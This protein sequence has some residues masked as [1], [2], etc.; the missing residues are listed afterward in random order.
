MKMNKK[1]VFVD[2]EVNLHMEQSG[3]H[4][5]FTLE[6]EIIPVRVRTYQFTKGDVAF[7]PH[8]HESLEILYIK[9]GSMLMICNDNIFQA[10]KG[11]IVFINPSDVHSGQ[12]NTEDV[13]YGCFIIDINIL[14]SKYMDLCDQKLLWLQH[15]SFK[16][17]NYISEDCYLT[18]VL[19]EVLKEESLQQ[20]NYPMLI[21]A[22]LF[23]FL[24]YCIRHYKFNQSTQSKVN[25]DTK[26][27]TKL[28]EYIHNSYAQDITTTEMAKNCGF[29]VSYFCKFFKNIVGQT[30][31]EYLNTVRVNKAYEM[32]LNTYMPITEISFAVG[33]SS[34]NYF[35]RQFKKCTN[36][37]PKE[38]RKNRAQQL[39][40]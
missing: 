23:L 3:K 32:V 22:Q 20:D 5:I 37:T 26:E 19:D 9:E 2:Y 29:S 24:S 33:Y 21:K 13:V 40:K 38:V 15:S 14:I 16:I 39:T 17:Q 36:Y 31:I 25:S 11:D 27:I 18:S 35:S 4:E 7:F 12:C 30:P 28:L 34:L 1:Y 8:W 10:Y 6:C